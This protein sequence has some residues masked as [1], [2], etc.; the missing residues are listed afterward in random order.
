MLTGRAPGASKP[1]GF[2]GF[3]G[4]TGCRKPALRTHGRESEDHEDAARAADRD[5]PR[6]GR[7]RGSRGVRDAV[8]GAVR[9]AVYELHLGWDG[10]VLVAAGV[11]IPIPYLLSDDLITPTCPCD[12]SQVDAL[13]RLTLDWHVAGA[14][15]VADGVVGAAIGGVILID[16]LDVR[17]AGEGFARRWSIW[18]SSA[19]R[20]RSRP[21]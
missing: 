19:K 10:P 16:A 9:E 3:R 1:R 15:R 11:G 20:W 5:R 12:E 21:A 8:P 14:A 6:L 17:G 2:G 7:R 4:L 18:S 13:N